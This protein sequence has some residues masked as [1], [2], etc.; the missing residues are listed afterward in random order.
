MAGRI[1]V[2]LV[3]IGN[4]FSGLIQGIEYYRQNPSQ[5]VIGIIHDKL[6]GYAK[7]WDLAIIPF[8]ISELSRGVDP[9]KVYEYLAMSLPVVTTG[10]PHLENLP[11]VT[12]VDRPDEFEKAVRASLSE[13][14]DLEAVNNYLQGQT[15]RNRTSEILKLVNEL[16]VRQENLG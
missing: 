12:N 8:K 7:N 2:G 16:S 11:G 14:F 6:A 9:L 13:P 4:C 3:G 5:Q 10:M 15:W 1:K